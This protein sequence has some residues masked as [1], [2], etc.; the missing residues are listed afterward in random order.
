MGWHLFS[1]TNGRGITAPRV[2][3]VPVRAVDDG[4]AVRRDRA[5]EDRLEVVR[6]VVVLLLVERLVLPTDNTHALCGRVHHQLVLPTERVGRETH[7]HFTDVV[8][9]PENS[10]GGYGR[11]TGYEKERRGPESGKGLREAPVFTAA[12]VYT[13]AALCATMC[14]SVTTHP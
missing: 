5:V 4:R 9:D 10:G 14:S 13:G 11:S 8:R 3:R 12:T 7:T 1:P 6:R 2:L